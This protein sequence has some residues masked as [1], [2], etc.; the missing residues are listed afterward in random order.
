[1]LLEAPEGSQLVSDRVLAVIPGKV[2]FDVPG[3]YRIQLR[4][5]GYLPQEKLLAIPPKSRVITVRLSR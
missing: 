3:V 2:Y 5:D 1:M 4:A